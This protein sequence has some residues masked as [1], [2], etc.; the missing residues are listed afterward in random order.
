MQQDQQ[1][2]QYTEPGREIGPLL[3]VRDLVKQFDVSG[4]RLESLSFSNGRI[5][6]KKTL[7][8]AVS[9]V[10]MRIEEGRTVSVV[11]ESGCG[12]STL[13][14]TIMGLYR[15]NGGAVLYRGQRIDQLSEAQ[16]KPYRRRM[17]MV[18]Q[19]PYASLNPRMTLGKILR[20]P[21]AFHEPALS[22]VQV[23][24]RVVEVMEQVGI[25]PDWQDRFPHELSG[26]QRQRISIARALSVRP[27]FIVADEP[28]AALD[29][30]IQAQILNL[31][32]DL[33]QKNRLTYLFISHD[34]SVV[35]HI[36]DRV[37]VMYLGTLC[38]SAPVDALFASPKHPYTRALLAAIPRIGKP[39]QQQHIKGEIPSPI[40][41]PS[42]CVFHTRC[43][44]ARERCRTEIPALRNLEGS[45]EVSCHG[46][47]E[48]R[49]QLTS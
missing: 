24:E 30:S 19:D 28:I 26:G 36:S 31:L 41:L 47:E 8:H 34:L 29:V 15:P 21:I 42:G 43:P 35:E 1:Q 44:H 5:T 22:A 17:Q 39:F 25:D 49:L 13:A 3:E 46:I 40:A 45:V 48:G 14:R 16:L 4:G 32:M 11:G 33:Q 18:F 7:V 10:S 6:R 2:T 12:K 9:K 20:E 37:A 23:K 27:D 38:E